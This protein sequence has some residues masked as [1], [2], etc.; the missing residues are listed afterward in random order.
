MMVLMVSQLN[1][2]TRLKKI[3]VEIRLVTS[4]QYSRM[5]AGSGSVAVYFQQTESHPDLKVQV[6][7][8]EVLRLVPGGLRVKEIAVI[9]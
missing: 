1:S 3:V 9:E 2:N 7:D 4:A 5:Q 8:S 6:L